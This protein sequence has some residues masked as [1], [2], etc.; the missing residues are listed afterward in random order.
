MLR[1]IERH[2]THA[3]IDK[4]KLEWPGFIDVVRFM[5]NSLVFIQLLQ[6]VDEHAFTSSLMPKLGA[7]VDFPHPLQLFI[8]NHDGEFL[9]QLQFNCAERNTAL[10]VSAM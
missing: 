8:L 5:N 6:N 2:N 1:L 10:S 3:F 4:I 7:L 9:D